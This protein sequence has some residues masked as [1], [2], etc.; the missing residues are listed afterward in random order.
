MAEVQQSSDATFRLFDWNRL[1]VDGKPRALHTEAALRSIDWSAGPVQPAIGVPI[2][3]LSAGV[4]GERLARCPHFAIERF[5]LAGTL[6]SPYPGRLSVWMVLEGSAI[7]SSA[8]SGFR[9]VCRT[10]ETILSPACAVSLQWEPAGKEPA[11]LLGVVAGDRA[12]GLAP[13]LG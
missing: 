11:T 2:S 3:G 10:G 9:R 13:S 7:L 1:G 4:Q 6:E 5:R 8:T 12:R